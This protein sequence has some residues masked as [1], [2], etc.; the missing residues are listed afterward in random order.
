MMIAAVLGLMPGISSQAAAEA[1]NQT[2]N[3]RR[4][5]ETF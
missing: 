5:N 4:D 2:T 1:E 3:H